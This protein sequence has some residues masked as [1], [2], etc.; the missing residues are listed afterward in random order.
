MAVTLKTHALLN[1][2][3]GGVIRGREEG[4]GLSMNTSKKHKL[5]KSE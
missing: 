3:E 1:M 4:E 2:H 5:K